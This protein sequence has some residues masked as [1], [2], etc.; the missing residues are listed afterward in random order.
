MLRALPRPSVEPDAGAAVWVETVNGPD[1]VDAIT[2]L[3]PDVLIQAGAGILRSRIFSIPRIGTLNVHHGIAPLIK[4]MASIDWALW[5]RR[6]EWLGAT[7]HMIDEGIDMGAV[8]AYAPVSRERPG[9]GYA[10]LY[11]RASERAVE[12]LIEVLERLERGEEWSVEP[13]PGPRVYRSS[14]SG[15]KHAAL[16]IRLWLERRR[17]HAP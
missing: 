7:I 10:A 2:K 16:E 1:A 17:S 13:R 5:K 11:V 15:W 9:E 14:F 3:A 6:P 4:G 12:K 8:L